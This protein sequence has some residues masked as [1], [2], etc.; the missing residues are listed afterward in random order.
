MISLIRGMFGIEGFMHRSSF[1]QATDSPVTSRLTESC[2]STSPTD[3]ITSKDPA[4]KKL[5]LYSVGI[6][7]NLCNIDG[8]NCSELTNVNGISLI[9]SMIQLTN[10]KHMLYCLECLRACCRQCETS[11]V[12]HTTVTSRV[13]SNRRM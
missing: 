12:I 10:E 6:L 5:C 9:S 8:D 13:E 11:K 7:M 2:I 1:L 3:V 4:V